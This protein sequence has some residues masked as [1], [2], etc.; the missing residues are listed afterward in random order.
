MKLPWKQA[1]SSDDTGNSP[2]GLRE[3]ESE[4]RTQ[5]STCSLKRDILLFLCGVVAIRTVLTLRD[6]TSVQ[7]HTT[8]FKKK[9]KLTKKHFVHLISF[10]F[11]CISATL[12][13]WLVFPEQHINHSEPTA[14]RNSEHSKRQM[15]LQ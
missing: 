1:Q 2:F 11:L 3:R 13:L 7:I 9:K 5:N 6:L 8:F 14:Q 4:A 15:E 10:V 12:S